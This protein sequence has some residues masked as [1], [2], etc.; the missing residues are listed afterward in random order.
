MKRV[1]TIVIAAGV[2]LHASLGRAQ[3]EAS[4][5]ELLGQ[6]IVSTPSKGN[7]TD[8]TAP[9][10]TSV[11]TAEQLRQFGLRSLDEAIDYLALGM[12]T[13]S[14][15][16]TAEIGARGVLISEDYGN[17]VLLLV[18]GHILNE[19]WNGTAYFERG[20]GVPFE[21]IDHIEVILGPGSVLYGSQ[22]MLGVINIVTKRAKDRP[23]LSVNAELDSA[24]PHKGA[25][26]SGSLAAA[27]LGYKVGGGYGLVFELFRQPAELLLGV[28]HYSNRG[29]AWQLGPQVYGTDWATGEPKNFGPD[30]QAGTW[31]GTV[32]NDTLQAPSGY[33]QLNVGELRAAV[34]ASAYRRTMPFPDSLAGY[35]GDFDDPGNYELD[36][37]LNVDLSHR[38]VASSSLE[39]TSRLFADAYDYHWSNRSSAAED[40]PTDYLG[41]CS[42]SLHGVARQLGAEVRGQ[43]LWP[44]WRASTLLGVV[45]KLR[46][47]EDSLQLT[48]NGPPELP[49][50]GDRIDGMVAPYVAQLF[51]PLRWLDLN[52]G[53]RLD[54]DSR[55]GSA[56]SPRTA[57]G[58]TPWSGARLKLIYAQAFRA[59]S[60]YELSYSDPSSQVRVQSLDP[61]TVRSIETSI[62]QRFGRNRVLFGVFR[63]A[64]SGMIGSELLTAEEI[65]EAIAAGEVNATAGVV[66]RRANLGH[67]SNYGLNG[68][69]DGSTAGERVSYGLNV[70]A[71][72]ARV[73]DG[74][75]ERVLPVAPQTF[76]NLRV[77]YRHWP[78]WPTLATAL[79]FSD[80]RLGGRFYDGGFSRPAVAPPLL[81]LRVA[82]SDE[83]ESVKGLSYRVGGEY[84]FA[85]VEP[86]E[87]GA[88]LY[89]LDGTT[90]PELAPRA[91]LRG[92]VGLEYRFDPDGE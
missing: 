33:V 28:E 71:A 59:P 18:D 42:R 45:S 9:A 82:L 86:Y 36:R 66:Y 34:R 88:F 91:K 90:Q 52:L 61:E 78:S 22:A 6:S 15:L 85:R 10:T 48:G 44:V 8:T 16:H 35:T 69:F 64:W 57:L 83:L 53:L 80:R 7:E 13:S 25:T 27:G 43:L 24:L 55:F 17:H 32:H 50:G 20:A 60:A 29:P 26:G 58:V 23:G 68:A 3:V 49:R 84:S 41:G 72:S 65:D 11:I 21:L 37:F 14:P 89:A 5:E 75:G 67:I 39:V 19:A 81:A 40:C 38:W 92:F 46:D 73:D 31:G 74:E 70:T 4:L 62:E 77:A 1:S 12:V 76:G 63:S 87:I 51:S 54:Y 47:V 56:L 79:R 2:Y 30:A